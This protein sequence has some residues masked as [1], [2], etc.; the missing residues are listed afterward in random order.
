MS[1]TLWQPSVVPEAHAER[2][3]R[4][5]DCGSGEGP[6]RFTVR[7]VLTVAFGA[8]ALGALAIPVP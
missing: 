2:S 5:D 4:Y 7:V 1:A 8:V 3:P 6:L